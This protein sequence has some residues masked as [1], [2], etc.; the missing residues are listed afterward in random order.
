M[1]A[2]LGPKPAG[3]QTHYKLQ[4]AFPEGYQY[5]VSSRTALTGQMQSP[6]TKQQ[7]TPRPLTVSG[8]SSIEYDERILKATPEGPIDKTFRVYRRMD[9]ERK[10]DNQ[11]QKT[12]LRQEVRRLVV[13]RKD[14]IEVPFSPDGPLLWN[15]IDLVRTD[16]FTPALLGL[17]PG[18]KEVSLGATWKATP[19]AIQELT[20]MERVE[21]G[22]LTCKLDQVLLLEKR[23]TARVTLAGTVRGVNE[24]GPNRQELNG[25]YY[26]DL[27]SN[28]L[29]YLYLKGSHFL[30]DKNGKELGK[31][32]GHFVL[33]RQPLDGHKDLADATLR[34]IKVEPDAE[35]TQLLYENTG[36]GVRFLYPRRW[37]LSGGEGRQITLDGSDGSGLVLTLDTPEKAPTA[38]QFLTES[39]D[40]LLGQKAKVL[41]A[42][43][44]RRL[45]DRPRELDCFSLEVEMGGQRLD[46]T[47]Y[48]AR[49]VNGAATLAARLAGTDRDTLRKEVDTIARSLAFSRPKGQI[50]ATDKK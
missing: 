29:S 33:T 50:P 38:N 22:G 11:P 17:L 39:R 4:E 27:E 36:L 16:V 47:Y 41:H 14:N 15:E 12:A 8:E 18:P 7:P 20:D 48:V 42:E 3:A 31:I 26:F 44:P 19:E 25:Y 37:R 24:D 13:L 21:E 35:N 23:K 30:L 9:F 1:V 10:V 34:G 46:M 28:H 45:Q 49:Q 5:H 43:A 2:L 32:E 6:P 40:Y